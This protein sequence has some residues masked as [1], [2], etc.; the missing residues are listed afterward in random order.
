MT[1]TAITLYDFEGLIIR[2]VDAIEVSLADG[3]FRDDPCRDC[4]TE[5]GPEDLGKVQGAERI[6]PALQLIPRHVAPLIEPVEVPFEHRALPLLEV[7]PAIAGVVVG[8]HVVEQ[9]TGFLSPSSALRTTLIGCPSAPPHLHRR[10]TQI[11]PNKSRR[12]RHN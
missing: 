5:L 3:K 7:G 6:R 2:V 1:R 12:R 8:F 10:S 9:S 11:P 4:T